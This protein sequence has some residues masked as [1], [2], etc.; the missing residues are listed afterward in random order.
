MTSLILYNDKKYIELSIK[1]KITVDKA[2]FA[3]K[4]D[5]CISPALEKDSYTKDEENIKSGNTRKVEDISINS[6]SLE[7]FSK[8]NPDKIMPL[9][10]ENVPYQRYYLKNIIRISADE[11]ADIVIKDK[12]IDL[13]L[14]GLKL[15][16]LSGNVYVNAVIKERGIYELDK[17]TMIFFPEV[18]INLYDSFIEI[19]SENY[20]TSLQAVLEEY[21]VFDG[22]P[23]YKKAPR[24]RKSLPTDS[25]DIK[26]PKTKEEKP[27]FDMAKR[28]AMPLLTMLMTVG[29][30]IVLKRG[31]Y[32]LMSVSTFI[33]SIIFSIYTS[34]QENKEFKQRESKR[35]RNYEKYLLE[36]RKTLHKLYLKQKEALEFTYPSIQSIEKMI[37]GYSDRIYERGF[38]DSDFLHISLGKSGM[39]SSYNISYSEEIESLEEERLK[40]E[41]KSL[42]E[43]YS[44]IEE[45]PMVVDLKNANLGLVGEK[46]YVHK[47]IKSIITQ[48]CFFHSYHDLEII[49]FVD[50]EF[51]KEF[52]AFSYYPH[53]KLKDVN[54][55]TLVYADNHSEQVLSSMSGIL[56]GRKNKLNEEKKDIKFLP[57]YVF[58]VDE[59]KFIMDNSVME[60]IQEFDKRMGVSIIFSSDDKSK[61]A[62]NIKTVLII[63]GK[64]FATLL[65]NEGSL[66]SKELLLEDSSKVDTE[67]MARRLNA[68]E[69]IKGSSSR[70]PESLSF[71]DMYEVG[72]PKELK[73][74]DRWNK[75]LIYKSMA[76]PLGLRAEKDI[77]YLNLHEKAHGPHGLVAGTTGSGK[78]EIIQSFIL[79]LAVNFHPYDIGFLLIDY[80]GGGMANLFAKLPHLLGTI[81]NLDGSESLRALASIRSELARRQTLFNEAE[82]NNI[83]D[84]T[85]LYKAGKLKKP[86]PHLLIIS[87]EFAQLKQEQP[88][89][90][91]ELVST[92]RIGRSLGVHLILATQKPS[93][94]VNDQIWSNSKFKLALKVQNSAD[95]KEV[96]KT[97]DAAHITQAGRA[98]LQVGNNEIYELFQS[99]WSGAPYFERKELSFDSSIYRVNKIGQKVLLSDL[100]EEEYKKETKPSTELDVSVDYIRKVYDELNIEDIERPWLEPLKDNI[101]NPY[102]TKY[103]EA[104]F[105]VALKPDLSIKAHIGLVDIPDKQQ[106]LE[107]EFDFIKE[108]HLAI[109]SSQGFGKSICIMNIILDLAINNSPTNLHMYVLDFG[110]S[111][112]IQL[113]SMPHVADYIVFDDMERL[114]KLIVSIEN[115]IKLRKKLLSKALAMNFTMYNE[116]S[117]ERLPAKIIFIDNI[118]I[119][120][121]IEFD[122]EDW[123][124]KVARDGASLGIYLVISAARYGVLRYATLNNFKTK[125]ALFLVEASDVNSLMGRSKY[126]IPEVKGRA[127]VKLEDTNLMQVYKAVGGEGVGYSKNVLSLVETIDSINTAKKPDKIKVMPDMVMLSDVFNKDILSERKVGIGLDT[128]NVGI[129]AIELTGTVNLILGLSQTGKTNVLKIIY[130]Q[131]RGCKLFLADIRGGDFLD[132][133]TGPNDTC[134]DSAA[135]VD[136]FIDALIAYVDEREN[137]YIE[138][139]S[140]KRLKDFVKEQESAAIIIDDADN[141]IELVKPRKAEAERAFAKALEYGLS[142]VVSSTPNKLK[143]FDE[144]TKIFRA[145]NNLIILGSPEDQNMIRIPNIRNYKPSIDMGFIVSRQGARKVRMPRA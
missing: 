57:H 124:N 43:K 138:E 75:S 81:T 121:E 95:S 93:G 38:D 3:S 111:G 33:L 56:K 26:N 19:S 22:F 144:L 15:N 34:I 84:Y 103:L 87:D 69:H 83:N 82:V 20:K 46:P 99:A 36:K 120:K 105:D 110:N 58:I 139:A 5:L 21:S 107:Y 49:M 47:L 23:V 117:K 45:L 37:A 86:L 91:T 10:F 40:D 65:L 55:R 25:E 9:L 109:F 29:V 12:S 61:L 50:E 80:K 106:Q 130:S 114:G 66:V 54:V 31:M 78:S 123:I 41:A 74:L 52:E 135:G 126:K 116:I 11:D 97:E 129:Q 133:E 63:E 76:V 119:I 98:Y 100:E 62:E 136:S 115:E 8:S 27:K 108:G 112:L 85:K 96:I 128:E 59:P 79:S 16:I 60:Y 24:I 44:Y 4:E 53:F 42:Y 67:F 140:V 89:F 17:G 70:I 39:K 48:L 113:K 141:F 72:S 134:V 1:S 143:G 2:V 127:L 94:V 145:A 30:S 71:F 6:L 104:P 142:I 137:R 90:M 125:I 35:V 18:K 14:E 64:E 51:E 13:I 92:A 68:L 122:M 28:I 77:V 118:D 88:D 7:D 101:L 132:M 102:V 73:I 32:I 131:L